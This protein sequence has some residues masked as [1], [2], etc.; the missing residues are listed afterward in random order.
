MLAFLLTLSLSTSA[1]YFNNDAR[2]EWILQG[3]AFPPYVIDNAGTLS[4]FAVDLVKEITPHLSLSKPEVKIVPWNRTYQALSKG[5]EFSALLVSE[6][7]IDKHGLKRAGPIANCR[8]SLFMAA[9][10]DS[11]RSLEEAKQ[12]GSIGVSE[13]S[14][15]E[16]RAKQLGFKNIKSYSHSPI[17]IE[18]L[19]NR[20]LD[21]WLGCEASIQYRGCMSPGHQGA[22]V[23]TLTIGGEDLY[24]AFSKNTREEIIQDWN[25]AITI[26]KRQKT[27]QNLMQQYFSSCP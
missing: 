26:V 27:Y 13:N 1:S 5:Q 4:G 22:I 8:Y 25:E 6:S 7:L 2:E 12:L 11:I 23:K 24:I 19:L 17:K 14:A 9:G 15:T 18:G 21:A 3:E 10:R 20:R 16:R